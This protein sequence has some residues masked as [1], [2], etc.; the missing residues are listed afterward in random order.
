VTNLRDGGFAEKLGEMSLNHV[1]GSLWTR[2]GLGRRDRSLVTLGALIA[3]RATEELRL[4]FPIA[5]RNGLTVEESTRCS[6]T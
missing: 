1:F 2:P 5:V 3:L 6:T 4:H